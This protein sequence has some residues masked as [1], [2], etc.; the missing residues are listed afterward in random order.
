[1][2]LRIEDAQ[3]IKMT[4]SPVASLVVKLGIPTTISMLVTSIYNMA[5]TAFVGTLGIVGIEVAQPIAEVLTAATSVPFVLYYFRHLPQESEL[6]S[7]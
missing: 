5:D 6:E 1:M 4:E 3:Y 7:G 2:S